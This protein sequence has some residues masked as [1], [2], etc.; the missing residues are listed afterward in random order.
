MNTGKFVF[1]QLMEHS[2]WHI[3]RRSVKR[4]RGNHKVKTFSCMD[5]YLCMAFAQLTH[6]ESLRDIEVCLRAVQPKLYHM[7]IRGK[8]SRSTLARANEKRD[9]RIYADFAQALIESARKLY[10]DEAL[11]LELEETV[12]ALDSTTI[13]LCLSLFPWARFRK[14]K[15]AIKLHTL[16]DLRG[17][18]PSFIRITDGKVNDLYLLDELIPEAGAFYVMDRGYTDFA[19]LYLFVFCHSREIKF[20]VPK[21]LLASG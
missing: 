15:G 1:A 3:F 17:N 16:L 18:I 7:G 9:W 4:Y 6:R 2:P 13:D 12:Y 11:E 5:H 19:R 10:C 21:T 14:K 20:T 8:V